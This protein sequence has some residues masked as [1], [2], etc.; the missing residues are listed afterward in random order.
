MDILIR[1]II[2][3][4]S[5]DLTYYMKK[6]LSRQ[7]GFTGIIFIIIV[8]VAMLAYLNVDLHTMTSS[9]PF[10]QKILSILRDLWLNYLVP[11]GGYLKASILGLFR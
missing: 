2:S 6:T 3:K 7:R 8:G 5:V 4:K 9:N 1:W 10:A 11:L